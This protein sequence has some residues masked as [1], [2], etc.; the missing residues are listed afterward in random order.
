MTAD[1]G[2]RR[3]K[4]EARRKLSVIVGSI[5]LGGGVTFGLEVA[6]V[7]TQVASTLG[8]VLTAL[9]AAVDDLRE[10]RAEPHA[11]RVERLIRGD[12]YRHP[13]LM[14]FYVALA[15]FVISNVVALLGML[16]SVVTIGLASGG[17]FET[18]DFR[19]WEPSITLA[20]VLID[21]PVSFFYML[22]IAIFAAHR[23][24]RRPFLWISGSLVLVLLLSSLV[25]AAWADANPAGFTKQGLLLLNAASLIPGLAA[26]GVGTLW[27]R[28]NQDAFVM[29]KLFAQLSRSDQS[30]LIDLVKTLPDARRD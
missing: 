28:R 22:P 16:T 9:I 1:A 20:V 15:V 14:V 29:R 17:E 27:A 11:Q 5:L 12:V 2:V 19:V 6:D 7:P 10:R 24:Q 3:F 13:L 8:G 30:D 23:I 18:T 25:V 21:L 4:P 26:T